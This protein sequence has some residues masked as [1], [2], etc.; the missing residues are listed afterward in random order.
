MP[1]RTAVFLVLSMLGGF[2]LAKAQGPA[3]VLVVVNDKSA[4]SRNI[5][6]YYV[7]RRGIP[8]KNVCRIQVADGE[9]V[10]RA[11]YDR[12]IAAPI[13]ACLRK[14]QL[15]EQILYIVATQGVPLR[16][17]GA[18]G[19]TG[20]KAAVDSEL[21]LLYRDLQ[22][23]RPHPV[24]GFQP[25]P[26]FGKLD[27]KFTHPEFPLYLVTRLAAYD[28]QGVKALIDRAQIARNT[29][30]FVIDMKSDDDEQGN[31]WLRDT[32]LRLP[33]DRVMFDDSTKVLY[34]QTDVIGFASW[35][36]N[37]ANRHER[38]VGFQWLPGAIATEFVST[39]G[40]TFARPPKSWNISDWSALSRP[41][42]FA[43]SP[44]TMTADYLDEGASAATGHVDEP[45]LVMTPRPDFL[46][47]AYFRGRNLAESFYLSIP[48]LSWQNIVIGDPLMSL[49]APG[50]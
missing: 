38:H 31:N 29:G 3:N 34:K 28:F 6:E 17:E 23:G 26:F 21:A 39:N 49:G 8:L 37:D 20:D 27:A 24:A 35:G 11:T 16:I 9:D 50:K 33:A 10:P 46:L 41:K 13:A 44:Q 4:L 7:R 22:Q 45:Y 40:R 30:K 25:N 48:A 2:P 14:E 1:S 12:L 18:S 47:P 43:G 15:V 32:V 42:W 5:T 36:S 19:L